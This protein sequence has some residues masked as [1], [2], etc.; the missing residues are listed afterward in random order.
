MTTGMIWSYLALG[1]VGV[2]A[3]G[4]GFFVYIWIRYRKYIYRIFETKPFF[5]AAKHAPDPTAEAVEFAVDDGRRVAGSYLKRTADRRLG[6]VLFCHEF[7]ADRWLCEPYVGYLRGAGFD[8]L[9]FD[10]CNH[11]ASDAIV[12]YEP[13]QWVT[14]HEVADVRAALAYLRSRPDIDGAPI[15]LFGV[16]KGGSAGIVA[17]ALEPNVRAVITD[18]AFPTHGT[19]TRYE[20][21]WVAIYTKLDLVIRL[22]PQWFYV[23]LTELAMSRLSRRRKVKYQ[24]VE[25][26]IRRLDGRPL[27]MIH[28]ERDNYINLDIVRE[29]YRLAEPPKELWVVPG[30]KHNACLDNAG[31]EYRDRVREFFCRHLGSRPE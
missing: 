7:T 13:L 8:I 15:G 12:D 24:R 30:A 29:F 18:G 16:S 10:F 2:L 28:G 21:R 31:E 26:G 4:V 14:A 5:L 27:L 11:G 22:L 6:V 19:V 20:M 23:L 3:P 9:T 25:T 1:I 17:A